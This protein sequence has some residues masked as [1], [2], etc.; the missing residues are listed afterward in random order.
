MRTPG[1]WRDSLA[2]TLLEMLCV[3]A[4]ITVLAALVTGPAVR[5]LQRVRAD[6]WSDRAHVLLHSTV[7]QL[8]RHLQGEHDFSLITL[9]RLEAT[10]WLREAEMR[11][12]KEPEV[13]FSPCCGKD[14]DDRIV[15]EVELRRGFLTG[16]CS[17]TATKESIT[18][19]P[20]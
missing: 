7:E 19:V 4:I 9:E 16:A 6:Q 1:P 3:I 15:I 18:R 8:N 13:T 2:F 5:V 20:D 17:L 11:F 10:G 12:L 14:P